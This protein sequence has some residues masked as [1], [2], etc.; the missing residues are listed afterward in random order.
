[1]VDVTL[2]AAAALVRDDPANP[3]AV[4][5]GTDVLTRKSSLAIDLRTG[6]GFVARLQPR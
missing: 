5:L 1:V 3:A 2:V 6:G 4:S